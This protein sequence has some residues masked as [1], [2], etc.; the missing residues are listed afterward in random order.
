MR[1]AISLH[2]ALLLGM[3]G[4]ACMALCRIDA[5]PR[6]ERVADSAALPCHSEGAPTAATHHEPEP[7]E[8][9]CPADCPGC[10]TEAA[11]LVAVPNDLPAAGSALLIAPGA[12]A[13]LRASEVT[14]RPGLRPVVLG[15][16]LRAPLL[17][18]SSLRL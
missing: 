7:V 12:L 18:T 11:L 17:V 6:P 9:G 8:G 14:P 10:A 4:P 16:P 3:Q 5:E 1:L 13:L 15:P 2:V